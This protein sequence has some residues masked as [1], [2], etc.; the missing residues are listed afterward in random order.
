MAL[1]ALPTI[2]EQQVA[3]YLAAN[4]TG[5]YPVVKSFSTADYQLPL[6]MVKAGKFREI[7]PGTHVYEGQLAVSVITQAD[8]VEDPLTTHDNTV[9]AVYDLLANQTALYAAVNASGSR[10]H[11]WSIYS[12]GYDQEAQ[13]RA[14]VSV[15]ELTV[16]AQTL[17]TT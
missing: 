9:A 3:A 7:E 8:D 15:F 2:A 16:N 14:L 17:E 5:T 6:I 4:Y 13:E 11:L 10:F 12:T 1:Y